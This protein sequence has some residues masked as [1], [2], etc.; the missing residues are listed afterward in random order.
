[1]AGK[2][3]WNPLRLLYEVIWQIDPELLV[4]FIEI[5]FRRRA[6]SYFDNMIDQ[7]VAAHFSSPGTAQQAGCACAPLR[8]ANLPGKYFDVIKGL[9]LFSASTIPAPM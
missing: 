5:L 4:C 6:A 2:E 7:R 1:L 8:I 3:F 9:S